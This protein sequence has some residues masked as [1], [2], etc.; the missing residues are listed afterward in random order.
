MLITISQ[1]TKYVKLIFHM[2][3]KNLVPTLLVLGFLNDRE[4]ASGHLFFTCYFW[5]SLN[6]MCCP[7]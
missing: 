7:I 1:I 6:T 3:S 5:F 2:I 4:P